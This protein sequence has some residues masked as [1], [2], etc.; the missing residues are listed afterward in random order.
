[1]NDGFPRK[2]SCVYCIA[3]GAETSK[4]SPYTEISILWPGVTGWSL[5]GGWAKGRLRGSSAGSMWRWMLNVDKLWWLFGIKS[6][7]N[8]YV[9]CKFI[10]IYVL[11]VLSL[12]NIKPCALVGFMFMMLTFEKTHCW[13]P[14]KNRLM[15]AIDGGWHIDLT[16]NNRN[17]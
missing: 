14:Q 4:R 6:Y 17:I 7:T 9:P 3:R 11:M 12:Q 10:L 15:T 8:Y 16:S 5:S 2:Q 1:M 13:P